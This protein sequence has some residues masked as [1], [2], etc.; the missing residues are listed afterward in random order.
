MPEASG[1]EKGASQLPS[2]SD[3]F[4]D[5]VGH[6]V[7]DVEA[8]RLALEQAGFAPT[9]VSIQVNPDPA[10]GAPRPTGTG[11]V[12]AML[13]QGYIEVLF[14]TADTPLG[15][16]LDAGLARYSGLHL[17]AFAVAD[18]AREHA[19]LTAAGFRMQPLVDMRRP[20]GTADGEG[21]AAFSVVR[22]EPDVFPEGRIQILRHLTEDTVWQPRWLGHPNTA[23]GLAALTIA[24]ADVAEAADRFSRFLARP[25]ERRGEGARIVLDRGVLGLTSAEELAR[26]WPKLCVPSLPFLAVATIEVASLAAAEG[27]LARAGLPATRRETTLEVPF[28]PALGYGLWVFRQSRP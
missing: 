11:N 15:R 14:K 19:R 16:Q 18:S 17:A 3:I 8:A 27:V 1:A 13:G 9:P 5:H 22:V 4:L 23:S 24:V 21:V 6:F 26:Q 12:C 2:G 28:P 7:T 25:A 10:G 20:V